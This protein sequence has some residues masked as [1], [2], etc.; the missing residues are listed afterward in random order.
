M[1]SEVF[2][3]SGPLSPETRQNFDDAFGNSEETNM[4]E[5]FDTS[6]GVSGEDSDEKPDADSP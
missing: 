5:A 6:E 2:L 1:I 3:P 4:D